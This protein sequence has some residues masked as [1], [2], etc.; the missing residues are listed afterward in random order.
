MSM[1][2][3]ESVEWWNWKTRQECMGDAQAPA[4][5]AAEGR[6][7]RVLWRGSE[8]PWDLG[9]VIGV[10]DT[11]EAPTIK[12]LVAVFIAGE[13]GSPVLFPR[14]ARTSIAHSKIVAGCGKERGLGGGGVSGSPDGGEGMS[15]IIAQRSPLTGGWPSTSP[16]LSPPAHTYLHGLIHPSGTQ[17]Q[18]SS[19]STCFCGICGITTQIPWVYGTSFAVASRPTAEDALSPRT[20]RQRVVLSTIQLPADLMQTHLRCTIILPQHSVVLL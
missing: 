18:C 13:N 15:T 12:S 2:K 10:A 17:C 6:G 5:V 14:D 20:R 3:Y 11:V 4:S 9:L 1:P 19:T 16:F 7:G 8:G